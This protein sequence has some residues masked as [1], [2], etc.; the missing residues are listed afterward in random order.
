LGIDQARTSSPVC[1]D[2]NR[3]LSSGEISRFVT[4]TPNPPTSPSNRPLSRSNTWM[5]PL[6]FPLASQRQSEENAST[7]GS[8]PAAAGA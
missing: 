2:E 7:L 8:R 5:L 3:Y 1:V 6:L 4:R